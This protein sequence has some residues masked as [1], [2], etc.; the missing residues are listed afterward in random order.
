MS[1]AHDKAEEALKALLWEL[2]YEFSNIAPDDLP[3]SRS[4]F[5]VIKSTNVR[6]VHESLWNLQVYFGLQED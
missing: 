1:M 6:K 2:P 4:Q 5:K 3:V